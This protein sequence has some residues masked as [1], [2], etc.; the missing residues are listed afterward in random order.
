MGGK[1]HL[2][3]AGSQSQ[4]IAHVVKGKVTVEVL[5]AIEAAKL[6]TEGAKVEVAGKKTEEK[7]E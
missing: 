6:V 1:V 5:W 7:E 3:E 2:V 4:A